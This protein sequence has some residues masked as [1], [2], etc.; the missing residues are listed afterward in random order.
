MPI[1]FN[2][3]EIRDA[4]LIKAD[5]T[6]NISDY[7]EMDVD[8]QVTPDQDTNRLVNSSFVL[9]VHYGNDEAR[10]FSGI[11]Q[12]AALRNVLNLTDGSADSI[13]HLHVVPEM[14]RMDYTARFRIFQELS[15][16]DIVH[17]ILKE[18]SIDFQLNLRSINSEKRPVCVQYGE[19]DLHFLFRLLEENGAHCFTV[20]SAKGSTL[21]VSDSNASAPRIQTRLKT[22]RSYSEAAY[23][24]TVV[25]NTLQSSSLGTARVVCYSFNESQSRDVSGETSASSS[26]SPTIGWQE[27]FDLPFLDQDAGKRISRVC[28]ER[29]NEATVMVS[30]NSYFPGMHTGYWIYLEGVGWVFPVSVKHTI[31]QSVQP[32]MTTSISSPRLVEYVNWF[33]ALPAGAQFSPLALHQKSR[34]Y[35]VQI[36]AVVGGPVDTIY[37]DKIGRI[38][39]ALPWDSNAHGNDT[40]SYWVKVVQ[41]WAGN[42]YGSLITPR[43]GMNVLIG[44]LNGDPDQPFCLGCA[45]SEA[46][47]PP[48]NYPEENSA[49]SS[50]FTR[51]V[52]GDGFNELKFNDTNGEEEVFLH[53]Q[54]DLTIFAGQKV[55][56][57]I[58]DGIKTL[59]IQK[60][61]YVIELLDGDMGVTIKKGNHTFTLQDGNLSI[62]VKGSLFVKASEDFTIECGGKLLVKSA[63]EM[64]MQ[65]G[66]KL[67]CITPDT[68]SAQGQQVSLKA[69]SIGEFEALQLKFNGSG[70]VQLSGPQ[71]DC[72]A[73]AALMMTAPL[74]DLNSS[75]ATS[76][77]SGGAVV[78][79]GSTVAIG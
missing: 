75:G 3:P 55:A 58:E 19:T 57:T 34:I 43:V 77:K 64:T 6:E 70:S 47:R 53:A 24:P 1:E 40:G 30:A 33:E 51:T 29:A 45:Y 2:C 48:G 21:H 74:I 44:F 35:G 27:R 14:A 49:I 41:P 76:I 50:F 16:E 66:G 12:R 72:A 71:I 52:D 22:Y 62:D 39:V 18:N 61:D 79:K 32:P 13:L 60:G 67:E 42:G 26:A 38:R 73:K 36:G 4:V 37:G 63:N 11:I 68:L 69:N 17:Q 59:T 5:I 46:N 23:N 56:E 10:Y 65:A 20:S 31:N 9:I 15:T 54:R 7:W 25:F 8:L 78:V 28:L